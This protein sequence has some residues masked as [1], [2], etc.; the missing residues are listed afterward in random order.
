MNPNKWEQ[1]VYLAEEKFGI[2]S[3]E[4]EEIVVDVNHQGEKIKGEKEII[5]FESPVG[6]MR[7]EKIT[8]PRVIDKNIKRAKRAGSRASVDLIYSDKET[9]SEM[10]VYKKN[11]QNEWE[12]IKPD[13]LK[14]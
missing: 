4:V 1:L 12:K 11:N 13:D 8:K 2:E 14:K 3:K 7:M 10:S 6:R 9:V 5:E